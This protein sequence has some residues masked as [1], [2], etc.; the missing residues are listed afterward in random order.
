MINTFEGKAAEIG[1]GTCIHSSSDDLAGCTQAS[2][3][4]RSTRMFA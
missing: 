3:Y 1:E 2:G 4:S